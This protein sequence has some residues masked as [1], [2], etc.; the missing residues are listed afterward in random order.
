MHD[1]R[2][3]RFFAID[4]LTHKYPWYSPYQFAGNKVIQFVELEGL[5]EGDS[6]SKAYQYCSGP[7]LDMN[8]APA[9]SSTNAKGF[10]R[11]GT[12]FWKQ[13]LEE[14]PEMFN[15]SNKWKIENNLAPV[16]NDQW[17][18]YNPSHAEFKN[19]RLIHH[20]IDQGRFAVGIPEKVH[21]SFFK[22]LH[23]RSANWFKINKPRSAVGTLGKTLNAFSFFANAVDILKAIDHHPDALFSKFTPDAP[24]NTLRGITPD[25]DTWSFQGNYYYEITKKNK[26]G[27][28]N[29]NFY[30]SYYIDKKGN[31]RGEGKNDSGIIRKDKAGNYEYTSK[32]KMNE[33]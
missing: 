5:E 28:Y 19:N 20:H 25:A 1:P 14:H 12:W 3:G 6:K 22:E 11:N 2:I 17:I 21:L 9:G 8:D 24:L 29:V 18:Q 16:A 31:Y 32:S 13:M 23:N 4:P 15:S 27:S 7:K 30:D 26:D 10:A 33:I